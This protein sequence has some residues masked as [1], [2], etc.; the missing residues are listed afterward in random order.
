MNSLSRIF[1]LILVFVISTSIYS[2]KV[3]FDQVYPSSMPIGQLAN[4]SSTN[5]SKTVVLDLNG[6]SVSDILSFSSN[7][8]HFVLD[9]YLN[10]GSANFTVVLDSM[11]LFG[12]SSM[13]AADFNGDGYDDLLFTELLFNPS[14]SPHQSY[15][16][17]LNNWPN[18]F[19]RDTSS[20]FDEILNSKTVVTDINGDGFPD[21]FNYS[22]SDY[23][24]AFNDGTGVLLSD[25][26]IHSFIN[27]GYYYN[28]VFGYVNS[29]SIKDFIRP[30][31]QGTLAVF[32][33]DGTG[34]FTEYLT[35]IPNYSRATIA[36]FN[37]DG[38]GDIVIAQTSSS[39]QLFFNNGQNQFSLSPSHTFPSRPT[40]PNM[41]YGD[42]DG[43]GNGDL[44]CYYAYSS[45]SP[46]F[47]ELFFDIDSS[48]SNVF[49]E[50]FLPKTS[51][52]L[53]C[54]DFNSDG[55]LDIVTSRADA[56]GPVLRPTIYTG[57]SVQ[58][59][60]H[61]DEQ[62]IIH[63]VHEIEAGFLLGDSLVD[64][65]VVGNVTSPYKTSLYH[66]NG[67][68]QYTRQ[69]I[70]LPD[71]YNPIVIIKDMNG[72]GLNDIVVNG[73]N[74]DVG[75]VETRVIFQNTQRQFNSSS[76]VS[77]GNIS[78]SSMKIED[79]D[80]DTTPDLILTGIRG[81]NV[82][83]KVFLNT[84]GTGTLSATTQSLSGCTNCDIALADFDN[85]GDMDLIIPKNDV[86]Y[87]NSGSGTFTQLN[88]N[89][90]FSWRALLKS[91]CADMDADGDVDVFVIGSVLLS[92][93]GIQVWAGFYENTGSGNFLLHTKQNLSS[94]D[95]YVGDINGDGFNEAIVLGVDSAVSY[96]WDQ[97][98]QKIQSEQ[99]DLPGFDYGSTKV[100]D[101]NMDGDI[102]IIGRY[103]G[104]L[105]VY[106]NKACNTQVQLVD[107][108]ISCDHYEWRDGV[109]YTQSDSSASFI[110]SR[111][112]GCDEL[113]SL[114]LTIHQ[115]DSVITSMAACE[116]YYWQENDSSYLESTID[117]VTLT[118]SNGCDSIRILDLTIYS[119][120]ND[121]VF[122]QGGSLYAF[123]ST[124][125]YQWFNC[126]TRLPIQGATQRRFTPSQNG[127]Y[128]VALTSQLCSDTSGCMVVSDVGLLHSGKEVI[129]YPIPSSRMLRIASVSQIDQV[130]L[131][132]ALGQV[133]ISESVHKTQMNLDVNAL[134]NGYYVLTL[135]FE[136]G[137][138]MN[139]LVI[140]QH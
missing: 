102:D 91:S 77:G 84:S 90:S 111:M 140:V 83:T 115:P 88:V 76:V 81:G 74:D 5:P 24:S 10:D 126:D 136:N 18:G 16:L 50:G 29:D 98:S 121:S 33:G 23:S 17:Y 75:A 94:G 32:I 117:T 67:L 89:S 128:A 93:G 56:S 125:T 73:R 61:S 138:I 4:Y 78:S 66:H 69:S 11:S 34:A 64:I 31:T 130:E 114:Y 82:A 99:L 30:T 135:V 52:V 53:G 103:A 54:S 57:T 119:A 22:S 63:P 26:I 96:W 3:S 110:N 86:V 7:G 124:A 1:S 51:S 106:E 129:I 27:G 105:R 127:T 137:I 41:Y 118:N 36:D 44:F 120:P 62:E 80:G 43:D 28:L 113:Y 39:S 38:F 14:Q 9:C 42:F 6:D 100:I 46:A 134:P 132:D 21:A 87:L 20:Y 37:Q 70:I 122:H 12:S 35:S 79:I 15:R 101:Y 112:F 92:S 108:I 85:D 109:I 48:A 60:Y 2:Q 19:A 45:A 107:S 68:N 71:Y 49:Y 131:K 133:V 13:A 116:I 95:L 104:V 72:D 55:I 97:S 58:S 25:S 139:E 123:D 59:F 8:N 47:L 65:I 40:S